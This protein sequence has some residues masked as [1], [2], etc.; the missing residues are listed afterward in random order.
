MWSPLGLELNIDLTFIIRQFI[1]YGIIAKLNKNRNR[2][3]RIVS[4]TVW[5]PER[6]HGSNGA[7]SA[8]GGARGRVERP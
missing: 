6:C 1:K 5:E 2:A 7:V 8:Y 3:S 4:E